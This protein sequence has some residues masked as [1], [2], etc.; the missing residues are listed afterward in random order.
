MSLYKLEHVFSMEK[1][2]KSHKK[3]NLKHRFQDGMMNLKIIKQL[4]LTLEC[5]Y[6]LNKL[7]ME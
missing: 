3:P 1:L 4:L 7:I 6:V 5:K 2:E